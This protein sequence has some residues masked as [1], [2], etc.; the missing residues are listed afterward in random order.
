MGKKIKTTKRDSEERRE[1]PDNKIKKE[2]SI[3][4]SVI[5]F[6]S[7]FLYFPVIKNDFHTW[8][9]DVY[10][11]QNERVQK[12]IN[13][14]NIVWA[15]TT[16]YFGFYYPVT[17]LSHMADCELY[18]LN[19]KGHYF[20]NILIHSLTGILL[21]YFLLLVTKSSFRS[22]AVSILFLLHPMNVESVAWI[23][24]RKNLLSTFFLVLALIC[25]FLKFDEMRKDGRRTLFGLCCYLFF[26]LGLMSKSSI[27]MFPVLLLILDFWPL[28]RLNFETKNLL[29]LVMEKIPFF[30]ISL[31][32]GIVTIVSQREI[33]AMEPL[34]EVTISDRIG[35]SFFGYGFYLQKFFLPLNL[36][37]LYPHHKGNFP[38]YLPLS[39]FILIIALTTIFFFLSK[40]RPVLIS[41]WL[42]FLISLFPVIG[43]LQTGLQA[44][45]D[46]YVYFPYW[47]LFIAIV[48]GIAPENW[49]NKKFS[50]FKYL[51]AVLFIFITV[52]LFISARKQIKTWKNDETLF[53]NV[54][55]VC[56]DAFIAPFQLGFVEKSRGN[57]EKAKS[58]YQ[59][60]LEIAEGYI[61]R[62]PQSG[63][64]YH[65]K[66]NALLM[67]ERYDEAIDYF[68]KA[69]EYGFNEKDNREKI[70]IAKKFKLKEYVSEGRR[71]ME[72]QKWDEAE[73]AFKKALQIAPD[74]PE[75]WSNLGHIK[76]QKNDLE[77]AHKAFEKA[78]AINPLFDNVI[79]NIAIIELKKN[80]MDKVEERL[81]LLEKLNSPYA[82][83][84]RSFF[85]PQ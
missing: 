53:Q 28:K 5:I 7:L 69:I 67:L 42:F 71:L 81:K 6:V 8:D 15:F 10:V 23:A 72:E 39:I 2:V 20:T 47:G 73:E 79:F 41:G 31:I 30:I 65:D 44:Y 50:F 25:Y 19:P 75:L 83:Q 85:E 54:M 51:I 9:D 40:R 82:A 27:V 12:G 22:F 37:V 58:Y 74:S 26:I 66:A 70:E 36:C 4:I 16:N 84:L 55:K 29:N 59:K 77:G 60:S 56:P 33:T 32:F 78:L 13:F 45:A 62:R 43:L 61:K 3:F 80:E 14:E 46:R 38:F 63:R 57:Y 18:G 21:F 64:A 76:D 24:E 52:F 1:S 35:E 17:W 34:S 11:R 48:Y 49:F 68:E